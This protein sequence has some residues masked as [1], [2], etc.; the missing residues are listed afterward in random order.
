MKAVGDGMGM[1]FTRNF[2][3]FGHPDLI[4]NRLFNGDNKTCPHVP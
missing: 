1:G 3:S 4:G 2:Q